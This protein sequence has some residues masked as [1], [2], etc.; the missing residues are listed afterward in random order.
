MFGTDISK[1]AL[2]DH[3]KHLRKQKLISRK[4]EDFQN[5]S[6][7][8]TDEIVSLLEVS[9]EELRQRIERFLDDKLLPKELRSIPFDAKD[10]YSKLSMKQ[11]DEMV[12][13]HH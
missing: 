6:Y 11:L 8:L 5:V 4:H 3:I 13:T 10:Y 12:L 1:P 9:D 2:I 7:G